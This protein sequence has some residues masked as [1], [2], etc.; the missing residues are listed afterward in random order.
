MV[1]MG[2]RGGGASNRHWIALG[3]SFLCLGA[4]AQVSIGFVRDQDWY[5]HGIWCLSGLVLTLPIFVAAVRSRFDFV[6][7]NHRAMFVCAFAL[8]FLLGALLLAAGPVDQAEQSLKSY[9]IGARGALRVDAANAIGFGCAL[10]VSGIARGRFLG[11]QARRAAAV[12]SQVKPT[13]AIALMLTVGAAASFPVLT[14]DLGLRE[15]IVNGVL[16]SAA[17]LLLVAI[18]IASAIKGRGEIPLRLAAIALALVQCAIGLVLF[19]KSAVMLPLAAVMAGLAWRF[20]SMRVIPLGVIALIAAFMMIGGPTA[21]ARNSLGF[22]ER[23]I[24]A[25]W[26]TFFDGLSDLWDGKPD[27]D[28]SAW[29]RLCHVPV[30]AAALDFYDNGDGGDDL[31]LVPWLPIPRMFAASKPIITRSAVDF[32]VKLTGSDTSSTGMGVF[33]SGYYNAGWL[34]LV[35]AGALGGLLLSQ[36]SAVAASIVEQRAFLMLPL[37]MLGLYMAFR[38]DGHIVADYLGSFVVFI[39]VLAIANLIRLKS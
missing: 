36:T 15:G 24:E 9:P 35:L 39:A 10:V 11:S 5:V 32:N 25:R 37:V 8:Y 33:V 12:A 3:I 2:S 20:G 34:G 31:G 30:Q 26:T 14:V 6:L 17:Q 21:Y 7:T 1:D 13:T 23:S 4:L 19:N 38:V 28:Y 27:A 18:L 16:R 29:A 22:Q